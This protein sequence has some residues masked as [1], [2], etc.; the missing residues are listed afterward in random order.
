M[1]IIPGFYLI[2]YGLE[3]SAEANLPP[4][5]PLYLTNNGE[6]KQLTVEEPTHG[7]N[8]EVN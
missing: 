4:P 8:Q 2:E 5:K 1:P 3:F 6:G 7:L